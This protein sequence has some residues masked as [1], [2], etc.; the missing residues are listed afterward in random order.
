MTHDVKQKFVS[1]PG[2]I[3]NFLRTNFRSHKKDIHE[4]NVCYFLSFTLCTEFCSHHCIIKRFQLFRPNICR[5]C[6]FL[7]RIRLTIISHW[8]W[9]P[10]A[11]DVSYKE[12]LKS[13]PK[14]SKLCQDVGYGA[15][16]FTRQWTLPDIPSKKW[17]P[18]NTQ[19]IFNMVQRHEKMCNSYFNFHSLSSSLVSDVEYRILMH[20]IWHKNWMFGIS[21]DKVLKLK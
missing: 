17:I 3:N 6:V 11:A 8:S 20:K 15:T 5:S 4:I 2:H 18:V 1:L 9:I 13:T 14:I 10:R 21:G 12:I 19:S 7:F 16:N